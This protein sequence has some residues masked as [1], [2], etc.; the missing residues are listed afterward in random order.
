MLKTHKV[1]DYMGGD[2]SWWDLRASFWKVESGWRKGNWFSWGRV[3]QPQC[4]CSWEVSWFYLLE[5]LRTQRPQKVGRGR[6][7]KPAEIKQ[8]FAWRVVGPLL[9]FPDFWM[10]AAGR[11]PSGR[12]LEESFQENLDWRKDLQELKLWRRE[13]SSDAKAGRPTNPSI[14]KPHSCPSVS[15]W[16]PHFIFFIEV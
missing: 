11:Y 4:R 5:S 12:L 16:M 3:L 15:F 2:N 1:K 14:H 13:V 9:P 7:Q 10:P 6:W 8:R